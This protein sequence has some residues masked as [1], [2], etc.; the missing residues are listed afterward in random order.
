MSVLF[1]F[2]LS[3]DRDIIG[4]IRQRKSLFFFFFFLQ[5]HPVSQLLFLLSMEPKYF[6]IA[7]LFSEFCLNFTYK[8]YCFC[9]SFEFLFIYLFYE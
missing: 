8:I 3:L 4:I 9:A 7:G 6:V 5:A 2:K 1:F